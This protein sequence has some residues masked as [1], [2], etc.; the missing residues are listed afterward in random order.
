MTNKSS[1]PDRLC[2]MDPHRTVIEV[3][4]RIGDLHEPVTPVSDVFVV[5]H[6]GSALIEDK[7][8]RLTIEGGRFGPKSLGMGDLRAM[9]RVEAQG[10]LQCA[11][12]P[13]RADHPVRRIVNVE[14]GGVLLRDLLEMSGWHPATAYLWLEGRDHGTY[15]GKT[16][17]SYIKDIPL[18]KALAGEVLL[19]Y[20]LN[21]QPLSVAH[22]FPLRA[23]VLGYYGTNSVKWLSRI[24]LSE[25]RHEGLFTKELYN[26]KV[27]QDGVEH[28]IPD[29]DV[30]PE[31][32]II[33]PSAQAQVGRDG[34][35]IWGW[36]WAASEIR[37]VEISTDGARSWSSADVE[38]RVDFGWQKFSYRWIPA[39]AG[40]FRLTS[41][42]FD[43]SGNVQV[44]EGRHRFLYQ[45]VSVV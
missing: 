6:L 38:R 20:E 14:W 17:E 33:R 9:K 13:L 34:C 23:V 4:K 31:S 1:A 7:D 11:G 35:V 45:P 32:V 12:N 39:E 26:R 25:H 19:A 27:V 43:C 37:A 10:F 36:A 8:F 18:A 22:G 28:L 2:L 24:T 16:V 29:W 44:D 40:E 15:V 5:S 3:P 30:H 21:G 41:R 42:A